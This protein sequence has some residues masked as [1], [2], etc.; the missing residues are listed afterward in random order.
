MPRDFA[1]ALYDAKKKHEEIYGNKPNELEV[2]S[3]Y[4]DIMKPKHIHLA[5]HIDG[6]KKKIGGNFVV[7]HIITTRKLRDNIRTI[8]PDCIFVL[9]SIS[10]ETQ[11]KR[12][13]IRHGDET[14]GVAKL[15]TAMHDLFELPGNDEKNTYNIEINED[16]TPKEVME[17]VLKLLM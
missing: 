14:D 4:K 6:Q 13:S 2:L 12:I 11:K 17:K 7:S 8:L 10:K 5:K 15:L 3:G 9:L 1:F 16:M